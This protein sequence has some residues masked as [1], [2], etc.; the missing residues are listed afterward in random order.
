MKNPWTLLLVSVAIIGLGLAL[1]FLLTMQESIAAIQMKSQDVVATLTVTG[2][3]QADH[4]VN[5]SSPVTARIVSI[6]ADEVIESTRGS[7]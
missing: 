1:R 6:Q 7:Y 4:A 3:V 5:F 2:E